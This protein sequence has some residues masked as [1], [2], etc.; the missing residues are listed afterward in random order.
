MLDVSN[1]KAFWAVEVKWSDRYCDHPQELESLISFCLE[2]KLVDPMVTSK[3]K[4][5]T[6]KASGVILR[7]VPASIYC[8]TVGYNLIHNRKKKLSLSEQL[9][10]DS[11]DPA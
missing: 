6:C 8:Y 4:T 3:T 2:N 9:N 5:I 7:F 1:Q 11:G 10:I